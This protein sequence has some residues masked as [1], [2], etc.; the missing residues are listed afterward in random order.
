MEENSNANVRMSPVD[1]VLCIVCIGFAAFCSS[2][3]LGID[4]AKVASGLWP[5]KAT[6]VR[7]APAPQERPSA[8][9]EALRAIQRSI[10]A[11]RDEARMDAILRGR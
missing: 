9:I 3:A 10:D 2:W 8:E 1:W 7:P 6:Y 5:W 11:L 4:P